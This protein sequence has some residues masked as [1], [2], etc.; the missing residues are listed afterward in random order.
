MAKISQGKG[1]SLE[2]TPRSDGDDVNE[3]GES[4]EVITV[5]RVEVETVGV[6]RRRDQEVSEATPR[7][8]PLAHGGGN[9]ESVAAGCRSVEPEWIQGRF[10]LLQ[11]RLGLTQVDNPAAAEKA[12]T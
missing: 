12:A 3:I 11:T 1:N 2:P 6:R 10:D 9:H 8:P 7:F 4:F 5:A